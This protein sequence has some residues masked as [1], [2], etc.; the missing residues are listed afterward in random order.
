MTS[1][2]LANEGNEL[3]KFGKAV[4][5]TLLV[6]KFLVESPQKNGYFVRKLE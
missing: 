3:T 6:N 1:K 4:D 2:Q 5:L